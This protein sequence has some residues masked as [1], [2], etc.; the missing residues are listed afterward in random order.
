MLG[1]SSAPAYGELAW[2]EQG[3]APFST[4]RPMRVSA[5]AELSEAIVSTGNLK[6]LTQPPQWQR[7]GAL[8]G[9]SAASAATATSCT[10][11]C[12]RAARSMS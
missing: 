1:V 12:W 11:T 3:A 2:A 10:T 8:V 6:T 4:A 7:F 9:A 5:V